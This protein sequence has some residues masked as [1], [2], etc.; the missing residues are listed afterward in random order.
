MLGWERYGLEYILYCEAGHFVTS[1]AVAL[2]VGLLAYSWTSTM[3]CS[4]TPGAPT[5]RSRWLFP[6]LCSCA[7]GAWC[8]WYVDV[9]TDT[10]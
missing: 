10:F 6:L 3:L 1:A 2:L 5:S 9:F 4:N 7:A 8:H